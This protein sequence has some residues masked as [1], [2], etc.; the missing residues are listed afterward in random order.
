MGLGRRNVDVVP[1][2]IATGARESS[3]VRAPELVAQSGTA[4]PPANSAQEWAARRVARPPLRLRLSVFEPEQ[5]RG[6]K[7][8][9]PYGGVE[10]K[11]DETRGVLSS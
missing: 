6:H 7:P 8:A 10:L 2:G 9:I 1:R 11:V 5:R 3:T 4:S